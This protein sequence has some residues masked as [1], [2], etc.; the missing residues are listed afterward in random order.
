MSSNGRQKLL[1]SKVT[2]VALCCWDENETRREV[3][4]V[5]LMAGDGCGVEFESNMQS[6]VFNQLQ[7][8]VMG[9]SVMVWGGISPIQE[10]MCRLLATWQRNDMLTKCCVQ[11][12]HHLLQPMVEH[13]CTWMTLIASAFLAGEGIER[14][15]WPTSSPNLNPIPVGL[16][17]AICIPPHQRQQQPG[18]PVPSSASLVECHPTACIVLYFY[19]VCHVLIMSICNIPFCHFINCGIK[20]LTR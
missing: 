15:V 16:A 11:M 20:R 3:A 5:T 19:T 7:P 14:M 4:W 6:D 8:M 9:S 18:S 10:N 13:L 17:E 12:L 2:K 1:F